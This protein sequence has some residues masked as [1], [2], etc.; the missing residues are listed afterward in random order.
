M[1][2]Y[3]HFELSCTVT[4]TQTLVAYKTVHFLR[5]WSTSS[6]TSLG[7]DS[8]WRLRLLSSASILL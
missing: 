1:S 2:K 8:A 3:L 7:V 6:P 4:I 5:G